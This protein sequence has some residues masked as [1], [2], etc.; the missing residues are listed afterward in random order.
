MGASTGKVEALF[1]ACVVVILV[2]TACLVWTNAQT[3]VI[4][5]TFTKKATYKDL[6]ALEYLVYIDV[7]VAAYSLL[8][9]SRCSISSW[10]CKTVI[11]YEQKN[12][13][14]A[15]FLLDQVVAYVAF[16]ANTAAVQAAL[17]AVTGSEALQWMKLCNRFTRFC[18]QIGGSLFCGYV[19]C[20]LLVAISC[21]SAF[22]LFRLY[23]P[24]KF[25]QLKQK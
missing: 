23:S 25:M 13:A 10:F 1:R 2:L 18:F 5:Y 3:K 24:T 11:T 20:F 8:Q 14:W 19:A 16:S 12:L 4:M 9:L 7:A 22:N 6:T 17:L 21:I 15:C